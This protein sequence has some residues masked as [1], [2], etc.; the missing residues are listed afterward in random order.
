MPLVEGSVLMAFRPQAPRSTCWGR[1]YSALALTKTAVLVWLHVSTP[2]LAAA[3]LPTYTN[4]IP[5]T[6]LVLGILCAVAAAAAAAHKVVTIQPTLVMCVN[7]PLCFDWFIDDDFL[8]TMNG[9]KTLFSPRKIQ[10][11]AHS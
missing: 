5:R 4:N 6:L 3:V 9:Q 7:I 1:L 10:R 8:Q 2:M 11:Q